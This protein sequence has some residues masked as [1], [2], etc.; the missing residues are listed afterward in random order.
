M[1][2]AADTWVPVDPDTEADADRDRLSDGGVGV[3][4]VESLISCDMHYPQRHL[5]S[6]STHRTF[7]VWV[8]LA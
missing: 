5:S 4:E 3:W 2:D 6:L 7:W 1:E 8:F